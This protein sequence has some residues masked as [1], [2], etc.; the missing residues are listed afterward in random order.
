M[1]CFLAAVTVCA[2]DHVKSSKT[3]QHTDLH[4]Q[5]NMRILVLMT[6]AYANFDAGYACHLADFAQ[7]LPLCQVSR[8]IKTDSCRQKCHCHTLLSPLPSGT[9]DNSCFGGGRKSARLLPLLLTRAFFLGWSCSMS[10]CQL[11]GDPLSATIHSKLPYLLVAVWHILQRHGHR[12]TCF[13]CRSTRR[14]W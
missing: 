14:V 9:V 8:E 7:Q 4:V 5:P 12:S 11:T 6:T 1:L 3:H 13:S 2:K 10:E